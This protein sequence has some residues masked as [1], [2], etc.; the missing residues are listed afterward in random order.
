MKI[1][2]QSV[3]LIERG[4]SSPSEF[5]ELCAKN[6]YKS[7][8]ATT[9][10]QRINFITSLVRRGHTSVFEHCGIYLK[11]IYGYVRTRFSYFLKNPYTVIEK[12]DGMCYIYTNLRV[13]VE[14]DIDLFERIILDKPTVS[15]FEP[16][17]DDPNRVVTFRIITDHGQER[18]FLRHR[19]NS[20]TIE[21]TRFI[22]YIKKLGITFISWQGQDKNAWIYKLSCKIS[23]YLYKLLI[24]RGETPEI[25]RT[26]LTLGHKTDII[27]SAPICKWNN[28]FDLR[29]DKSAH[30][31][32]RELALK[33]YDLIQNL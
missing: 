28:F 11:Y 24:K 13:I 4:K 31:Q 9:K 5:V 2:N 33:M 20:F 1:I 22:N 14:N 26:V 30:F 3:E 15:Y 10:E 29:L 27:M 19:Y 21:S 25:A 7:N 18:S 32:I 8:L 23:A 16:K 12:K 6:C 17:N